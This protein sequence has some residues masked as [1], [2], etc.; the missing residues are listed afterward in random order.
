MAQ[1]SGDTAG[2]RPARVGH[3]ELGLRGG[4]DGLVASSGESV[5]LIRLWQVTER[6]KKRGYERVEL[7]EPVRSSGHHL[8]FVVHSLDGA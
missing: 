6:V 7:P 2:A 4:V 5:G 1:A 3:R 8:R